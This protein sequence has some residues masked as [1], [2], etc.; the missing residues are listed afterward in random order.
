M[1]DDAVRLA[2]T[3][4]PVAHSLSPAMHVAA[5]AAAG[6]RG[7]YVAI[8][9][10]DARALEDLLAAVAQGR[11]HGLNVTAPHK[12]A[13]AARCARLTDEAALVGAVNT[14]APGP[15]GLL[16]DNTDT[17][18]FLAGLPA[19]LPVGRAVVV[20]AGG[21]ARAVVVALARAGWDVVVAARRRDQADEVAGLDPHWGLSAV[22]LDD[23]A[24][25]ERMASATLVVNATP[26]GLA[27]EP[28]PAPLMDLRRD[29]VAYDLVYAPLETPFLAAAGRARATTVDGLGMLVGQACAAWP[30]WG[31]PPADPAAMRRAA[32]DELARRSAA[33][34]G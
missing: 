18:G 19:D 30:L 7:S 2:V 1:T 11:L 21:A 6:I 22:G 12:Q 23:P 8:E 14:V 33:R 15:G 10:P 9:A 28:L 4:N 20:G 27:G 16:G 26:L 3:G 5:L 13:A 29:Q 17:V 25:P 32:L 24:W 31:L 34:A